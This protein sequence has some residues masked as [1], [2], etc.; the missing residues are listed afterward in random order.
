[1]ANTQ[2]FYHGTSFNADKDGNIG[3][4]TTTPV[5]TY[6]RTLHVKGVN[7]T[8]RIETDNASGW[9]YNQYVSPQSAWSVGINAPDQFHITNSTS[10]GSNVRLCIDDAT[11]FMGISTITPGAQLDIVGKS[12]GS[13]ILKLQ[14][15]GVGS[16]YAY[17]IS[18]AGAGALQLFTSALG[19]DSGYLFQTKN[20]G[21]TQIDA[22]YM[23]PDGNV[24]IG[25]N[26]PG[27]KLQVN[28]DIRGNG[29]TTTNT[30][31][32]NVQRS[33]VG[34][35]SSGEVVWEIDSTW[36]SK[37]VAEYFGQPVSAVY[38]TEVADAPGGSALYI[39][40]G[41][42][43]GGAYNSGFPFINVETDSA[44]GDYYMECYIQNVGTNQSHYMGSNEFNQNF[45]STG[46]N[47]GSYGYWVM[48][49]LNP[50]TSWTKVSG[51]I[52]GFDANQTGKFELL[53]KYWTPMAL[54]NYGAGSGTRACRI[55]GWKIIKTQRST[56]NYNFRG[57]IGIGN[58]VPDAQ[59][60]VVQTAANWTGSFKNY[61]TDG[62]GLRV[63]MSNGAGTNAAFQAYTPTGTGVIIQS[64]GRTGLGTFTPATVLHVKGNTTVSEFESIG[65]S[66]TFKC[67][68]TT[69]SNFL[70]FNGST[71]N[72]F[73]GGELAANVTLKI[74][75][76]GNTTIKGD[77]QLGT[78]VNATG[79]PDKFL[80]AN[81]NGEVQYR[82]GSQLLSDIGAG[83]PATSTATSLQNLLP[84]ASI[85][86][87]SSLTLQAGTYAEVTSGAAEIDSTGTYI[88]K[89]FV[90]NFAVAGQQYAETY[91]GVMSWHST[92]TNQAGG[93][94][95]SEIVLHRAGHAANNGQCYLRT[96]E[97]TSAGGDGNE[98]KLEVMSNI[99]L[100]SASNIVFNFVKIM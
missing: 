48:S 73:Q 68:N 15:N 36:S 99:T 65:S 59:L 64:N 84:N 32:N 17:G 4:G 31:I 11:T 28:G 5:A 44:A 55:S 97:T 20:S 18:D 23:D 70:N 86:I 35:Y 27:Y 66:L 56:A 46:G 24:G 54:L 92:S 10:L 71:F 85:T 88:V 78:I 40:G 76:N 61:T 50:G 38:W 100:N 79:D 52:G 30:R 93:M 87:T 60:D 53:T 37:Q 41:V 75:T 13:T 81:G 19:A 39:N 98:L 83:S 2:N 63:D 21:G 82:T 42:N 57:K 77:L 90:N 29:I 14:R 8:V 72:L 94:A 6:D 96:R 3:I 80:C 74:L 58:N 43:V 25:T 16:G 9:A 47:P 89:M 91:S 26:N 1:M 51:Y 34:H 45:G 69:T 22:L 95:I 7:P 62:Y 33:P 12:D 67:K 49:N